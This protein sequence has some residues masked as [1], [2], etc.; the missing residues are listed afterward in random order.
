MNTMNYRILR[1]KEMGLKY[2]PDNLFHKTYNYDVWFEN[3]ASAVTTKSGKESTDLPLIPALE[4][5]K[6]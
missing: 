2:D 1:E 4:S 3:E 6:K 5:V